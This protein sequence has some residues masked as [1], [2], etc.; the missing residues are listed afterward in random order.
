[1]LEVMIAVAIL[2]SALS[3]VGGVMYTMHQGRAAV[4]EEIKVQAI[5]QIMTERLQGA[6]WDDLGRYVKDAPGKSAWSW[7]RRATVQSAYAGGIKNPPLQE[8]AA[9]EENDLIKLGILRE[10]SGVPELKIYLEYYQ[11]KLVES[12]ANILTTTP[13]LDP[14]KVWMTAVGD[15]VRGTSPTETTIKN[16][17]EIFLPESATELSLGGVDPAIVMR[18]LISWKSAVGG[19][20]W[21][22][23]VI[24]RRK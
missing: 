1:M 14:R 10:P 15:P 19:T 2:A 6:K 24:A 12:V 11:M 23:V 22:E 4:D 7:H 8:N 17:K 16:D 20:R 18:V 9:K 3:M 5:A 21:H 13:T